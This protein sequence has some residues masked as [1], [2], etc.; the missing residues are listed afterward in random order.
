MNFFG[1]L[2]N[3]AR[4]FAF[5]Y[6]DL[7][8]CEWTH[9][10]YPP[11]P[12]ENASLHGLVYNGSSYDYDGGEVEIGSKLEYHCFNGQKGV[13]DFGFTFQEAGCDP[14]IQWTPPVVWE[15][16]TTSMYERRCLSET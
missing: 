6:N 4:L 9:C 12:P 5:Q 11:M 15:N 14:E 16:C 1:G 10:A 7:K 2:V 8:P 13:R 3:T